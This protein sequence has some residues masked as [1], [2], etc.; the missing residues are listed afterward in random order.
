MKKKSSSVSEPKLLWQGAE[1]N[2]GGEKFF[3]PSIGQGSGP[4]GVYLY[5]VTKVVQTSH[6]FK[7]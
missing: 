3:H 4:F 5:R 1:R 7:Y 6:L 2:I